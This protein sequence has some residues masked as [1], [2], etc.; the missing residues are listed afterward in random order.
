MSKP[1][2]NYAV[3]EVTAPGESNPTTYPSIVERRE[4]TSLADLIEKCIDR[5]LIAGLKPNAA[6]GLARGI[7]EQIAYEFAQGKG[8]KFDQY[9][10]GNLYLDG[11]TNSNGTLSDA[12]SVNVKL[13]KGN[14]F[15]LSLDMFQMQFQGD[16]SR[17]IITNIVDQDTGKRG[18]V[19]PYKYATING[20]NLNFAGD[21]NTVIFTE[22][23]NSAASPI[24][25]SAFQ[26]AGP[27]VLSFECP[28]LTAG[29]VYDVQVTRTTNGETRRTATK[30]VTALT[31]N[32]PA[33]TLTDVYSG[34]RAEEE[35][36]EAIYAHED[37]HL[38][39]TNLS[40]ASV[41]VDWKNDDESE[42]KNETAVPADKVTVSNT[43]IVVDDEWVADYAE[44]H[45]I[46]TTEDGETR[47]RIRF[48]ATTVS[49]SASVQPAWAEEIQ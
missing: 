43:E 3:R 16:A 46:P 21:T 19:T 34:D 30:P 31:F 8:V 41:K 12:N 25:V 35:V 40:G 49:G 5:G 14:L 29:K 24:V 11:T 20:E 37:V 48:T 7:S 22:R 39:G 6:E 38:I 33:P 10:Y 42:W 17:P 44:T 1:I 45:E 2:L 26:A 32:P 13:H 36:H 23:G 28:A 18:V 47:Y 15:K 4:N 27:S 9:F